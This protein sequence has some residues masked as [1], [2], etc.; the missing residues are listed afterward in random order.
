M[1]FVSGLVFMK[2]STGASSSTP[3]CLS[4]AVF[5]LLCLGSV[6]SCSYLHAYMV[7]SFKF[8]PLCVTYRGG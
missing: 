1:K 5:P 3:S 2:A 7:D 6:K 4:K 8:T